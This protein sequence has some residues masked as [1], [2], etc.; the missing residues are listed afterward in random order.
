MFFP[1]YHFNIPIRR[2]YLMRAILALVTLSFLLVTQSA[3]AAGNCNIPLDRII[4]SQPYFGESMVLHSSSENMMSFQHVDDPRIVATFT[5]DTP[6]GSLGLSKS[7]YMDKYKRGI[8]DYADSI[9]GPVKKIETAFFS[10]EPL[11]WKIVESKNVANIGSVFEGK[12]DIRFSETCLVKAAFLSPDS[13][14]LRNRWY[15]LNTKVAELRIT[16]SPFVESTNWDREDTA[17]TGFLALSVGFFAPLL[18]IGFVYHSLR[19]LTRL[20]TPSVS[21]KI[22][23]GTIALMSVGLAFTQRGAFIVGLPILKYTDTLLMLS[24]CFL[25]TVISSAFAQKSA[26]FALITGAVTGLSLLSSSA[27]GWTSDPVATGYVG[28]CMFF[29]S[30]LGFFAWSYSF[31]KE[32]LVE[33]DVW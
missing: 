26:V 12:M 21:T 25:I 16:G 23:I 7:E 10:L 30:L 13:T 5:T 18:L 20:G 27:I 1:V 11:A 29:I 33:E 28:A 19:H 17:P 8:S 32:P 14:S 31:K 24:A 4:Q 3:S 2:I 9:R 22:V 6:V 15:E